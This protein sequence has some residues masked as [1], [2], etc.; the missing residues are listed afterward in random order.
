[1]NWSKT[2]LLTYLLCLVATALSA[3]GVADFN[4]LTGDFILQPINLYEVAGPLA[5]IISSALASVALWKGW[6]K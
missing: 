2:R 6:G 4:P 1:M 5:G 3:A